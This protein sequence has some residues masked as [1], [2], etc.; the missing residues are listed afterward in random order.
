MTEQEYRQHPGINKSTLWK[1][2]KSP[3]HYKWALEHP[4]QDT[5]ALKFG[6]AVHMAVLQPKEF[7]AHYTVMPQFDRRTREGKEAY[8]RFLEQT[9]G[10]EYISEDDYETIC[11]IYDSVRTDSNVAELLKRTRKEVSVFWKDSA[12]GLECKCRMDAMRKGLVLD[13]KSC[14]DASTNTFMKDAIRYGYDVQCAHYLRGHKARYK[15]DAEWFFVAVEKTPPYA[16]NVIKASDG[17]IDRGTWQLIDLMDKLKE[18]ID[19]NEWPG[20]GRNELVLPEWAA[21]PDDIN[22]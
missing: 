9:D 7:T 15:T 12:T 14:M 21:I 1:L 10:M 19:T 6:R 17:F 13:L 20:Y 16:V 22:E 18:C 2:R 4:R 5:P 11:G 3:A 8:Q